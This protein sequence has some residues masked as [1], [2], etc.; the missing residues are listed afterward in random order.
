MCI[1]RKQTPDCLFMLETLHKETINN[2]KANGTDILVISVSVY[3]IV[4]TL[5][6]YDW[7]CTSQVS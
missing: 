4:S 7:V 1:S 5:E 3:S 6:F 2:S